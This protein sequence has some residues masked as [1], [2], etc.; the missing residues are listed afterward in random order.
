MQNRY[1]HINYTSD[2]LN[3]KNPV[4]DLKNKIIIL[5]D[6][7]YFDKFK[8]NKKKL[9]FHRASM[10]YF[11]QH[12]KSKGY[13]VEYSENN[14]ESYSKHKLHLMDPINKNITKKMKI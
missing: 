8:F 14:L 1:G 11:F 5:E 12:L 7:R 13:D 9:I 3:L 4:L 10:K 6:D 2:Q